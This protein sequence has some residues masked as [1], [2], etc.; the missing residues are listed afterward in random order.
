MQFLDYARPVAWRVSEGV[1]VLVKT[2]VTELTALINA[3]FTGGFLL[4]PDLVVTKIVSEYHSLSVVS[5]D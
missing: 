1:G 3:F 5:S 4:D 2:S